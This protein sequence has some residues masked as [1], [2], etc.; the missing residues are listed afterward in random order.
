METNEMGA[1]KVLSPSQ[2]GFMPHDGVHEHHY[3]LFQYID[4]AKGSQTDLCIAWLDLQNAL[5]SIPHAALLASLASSRVGEHFTGI[6]DDMYT[7]CTSTIMTSN[8]TTGPIPVLAGIR[9]GCPLSGILF[10]IAID[11]LLRTKDADTSQ[12][13]S[14]AF[15]DDLCPSPK[16]T[17]ITTK[18]RHQLEIGGTNGTPLQH[19][20]MLHHAL[21]RNNTNRLPRHGIYN[22]RK[23][24]TTPTDD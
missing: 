8:D 10:N 6:V 13:D 1:N 19:R 24:S 5:R 7:G 23:S 22:K 12:H 18:A 16:P 21:L 11:P 14:L 4:E 17:G 9:Q 3:A 15:A 20:Q 2:K